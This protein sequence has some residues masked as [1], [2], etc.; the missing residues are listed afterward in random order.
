MNEEN[1]RISRNIYYAS[2]VNLVAQR[3]TCS[4]AQVGAIIVKEGRVICTG[5][6]GSPSGLPHCMDVGCDIDDLTGGCVRT[7][8][9]ETNAIISASRFNISLRNT[10]IF[11]SLSPCIECAK[12]IINSGIKRAVY[13][14]PYRNLKGANLINESGGFCSDINDLK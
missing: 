5:Y 3:S 9:A 8:H 7:I 12:L 4:R 11:S 14:T 10:M 1:K 6:A 13:L 2:M